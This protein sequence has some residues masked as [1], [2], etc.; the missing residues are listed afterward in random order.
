MIKTIIVTTDLSDESKAAF[1]LAKELAK[2]F[3]SELILLA[4]VEDLSQAAMA[5]AMDF[6]VLPDADLQ[7]QL[8]ERVSKELEEIR[9][10]YFADTSCVCLVHEAHAPVHTEVVKLARLK[11]ADLIIMA[12]H[13]RT[14]IGRLLIGSV[15][16]K[17]VREAHCPVLTVPNAK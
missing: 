15:A 13:G 10:S 7:R 12:T 11:N 14:G 16:E 5:Y 4:V 8:L 6:P 3:N 1:P 17:I 9:K 2:R